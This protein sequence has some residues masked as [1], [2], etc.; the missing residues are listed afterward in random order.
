MRAQRMITKWGA[1]LATSSSNTEPDLDPDKQDDAPQG[2][3][4]PESDPAYQG[5][6]ELDETEKDN[7]KPKG[8][9]TTTQHGI[10]KRP[11]RVR[12]F[13]CKICDGI[14][15]TTKLWNRHYEENHPQ[16]PCTDCG[17]LFRNPTSLYRHRYIH[18]KVDGVY[19][20]EKCERVF[21]FDSQL[22]SHMFSHRKVSH[23]PCTFSGCKKTFKT[24]WNRN[25]HEKSHRNEEMVCPNCD[26]KTRDTRYMKQHSRVHEDFI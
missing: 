16:I 25:A 12:K 13:K 18:T 14:F 20:C 1:D 7:N 6:N 22:K 24:E 17:K 9:L 15:N 2:D 5:D 23:F 10:V 4:E 26:Y 3:N 21:P 19:P 8:K 11:K